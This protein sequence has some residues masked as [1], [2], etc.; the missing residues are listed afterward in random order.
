MKTA[1]TLLITLL[2]SFHL[3]G[4]ADIFPTP[5][6]VHGLNVSL[7]KGQSITLDAKEFDA[8]S[9]YYYDP[10][11]TLIFYFDGGDSL[12]AYS[13]N[14]D[15]ERFDVQ[16]YVQDSTGKADHC[17]TSLTIETDNESDI[18]GTQDTTPPVPLI[19][20]EI[21]IPIPPTGK[22]V[23]DASHFDKNSADDITN[24][25]MLR[26]TYSPNP[27]DTVKTFTCYNLGVVPLKIYVWDEA[28]NFSSVST[29][30]YIEDAFG[31]CTGTYLDSIPPIAKLRD[32]MI[33]DIRENELT[34]VFYPCAFD[35]GSVDEGSGI[36]S[37]RFVDSAFHIQYA[38]ADVLTSPIDL[39]ITDM[40][41]NE[42]RVTTHVY[43]NDPN[44][45]CNLAN[46]KNDSGNRLRL[47]PNP[48]SDRL[49]YQSTTEN[50]YFTLF[51]L[52]G[53]VIQTIRK[54]SSSGYID[55]H[56][57]LSGTYLLTEFDG[58]TIKRQLFQKL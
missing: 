42:T 32:P 8:G 49:H 11:A 33:L 48:A 4:Q 22:I 3:Y 1:F 44:D 43:I 21:Q 38:C 37:I 45:Y 52:Q 6:C 5:V 13:T 47:Y 41:G 17:T 46:K 39:K 30:L 56:S 57:L 51:S 10:N 2:S 27:C 36:S 12:R 35:D 19:Y 20:N 40:A 24:K 29:Y 15:F 50:G 54:T 53:K 25:G 34:D 31:I 23:L 7:P 55:V 14:E 9:F 18:I 28:N 26:F 58:Q 16:M